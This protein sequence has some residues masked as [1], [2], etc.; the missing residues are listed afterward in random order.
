[1]KHLSLFCLLLLAVW[2]RPLAARAQPNGPDSLSQK[3]TS[4]FAHIDKTQVPTGYLYE[5]GI[6]FLE[7]RYYNGIRSDSNLTDMDVLRYLRAQLRSSRVYG[8]DTLPG[9]P[10]FNARLKG[11]SAAAGGAIPLAIECMAYASIV[12]G[13]LQDNLLTVQNEQVYDVAGRSQSPYQT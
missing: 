6:R 12:P 10:A 3:L 8:P 5:A 13:A 4:I 1:M 11:A 2:L 7:P 9:L